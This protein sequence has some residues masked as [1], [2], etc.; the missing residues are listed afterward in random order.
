MLRELGTLSDVAPSL[1]TLLGLP[2][3]NEM[4]GRTL[5]KIDNNI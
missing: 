2:I 3:P 4:T 5:L 1:L